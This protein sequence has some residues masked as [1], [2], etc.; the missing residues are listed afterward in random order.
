MVK[1]YFETVGLDLDF[2]IVYEEAKLQ[3]DYY[4]EQKIKEFIQERTE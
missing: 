4:E 1:D 2:N 3:T